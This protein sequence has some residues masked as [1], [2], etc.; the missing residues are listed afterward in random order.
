MFELL[1]MSLLGICYVKACVDEAQI[2]KREEEIEEYSTFQA[3]IFVYSVHKGLLYSDVLNDVK[4][5]KLTINEIQEFLDS[6][7]TL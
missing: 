7:K 4:S 1:A 2:T 5:G 3:K 6:K